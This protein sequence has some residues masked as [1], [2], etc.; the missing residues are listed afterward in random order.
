MGRQG[1][2]GRLGTVGLTAL[3]LVG[4]DFDGPPEP[5]VAVEGAVVRLAPVPTLPSAGYLSLRLNYDRVTL[6]EVTSPK[7]GRIELH[8]TEN[9]NG[10][11]SMRPLR[12][13]ELA[14]EREGL[15]F[16]PGGKHLMLHNVDAAVRPYGRLPLTLRFD[17]GATVTVQ[18]EVRAAGDMPH[19]GMAH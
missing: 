2:G 19:G 17:T 1:F 12:R 9:R 18:A 7:V 15:R 6:V 13:E 14:V 11:M 16:E 10:V 8:A 4:C 5:P 3:F